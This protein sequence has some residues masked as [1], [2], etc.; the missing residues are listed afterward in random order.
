MVTTRRR[1]A[2]AAI[3]VLAAAA[4]LAACTDPRPGEADAELTIGLTYVPNVQFAPFYVADQRGY[5][6]EEGVAVELRHHGESEDLFGALSSGRED[7]VVAGG[8]EMLQARAGGAQVVS[9]A[10]VY[11]RYPVQLIVPADSTIGSAADLAGTTVGVPG[12]FGETWFGL[13]AMLDAAGLQESDLE[14]STIGFTQQAAL[15]GGYVDAVMG[16]GNNDVPQFR[17]TGLE[18]VGL[19]IGDVALVGVSLGVADGSLTRQPEAIRAVIRA[20]ER[21]IADI[22]A[23]PNIAV[24][25]A[26]EAIPGAVPQDQREI[27]TEVAIATVEL[28]GD[29]SPWG[30]QDAER[31]EAMATLMA[32][33]GLLEGEVDATT[34]FTN[35]FLDDQG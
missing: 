35:E 24:E 25:A 29:V 32:D 27:M 31:W 33:L 1:T 20:V 21:A 23:D 8:D 11:Q 13:L 5:F 2:S 14:I 6:A 34:A 3:A 30:L 15:S 7:I 26:V 17:A 4:L 28:Y 18:V 19:D 9:V 22:S 10:T 12:E 16:Y